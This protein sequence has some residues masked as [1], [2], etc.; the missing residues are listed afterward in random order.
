MNQDAT[1][2]GPGPSDIVLID[3][4]SALPP[5]KRGGKTAGWIKMALD[6]EVGLGSGHIVLDGTQLPSPEKG[7]QP[8]P[9]FGP[10]LL[11]LDG[12]NA[13]W[14]RGRPVGCKTLTQSAGGSIL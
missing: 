3:G 12:S 11:W 9:I 1:W 8:L 10:C 6:M 13:T 5:Q 2:Y 14:Y 7:A 4:D